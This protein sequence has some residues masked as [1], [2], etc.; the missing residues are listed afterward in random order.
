MLGLGCEGGDAG[1]KELGRHRS[2]RSKAAA[3]AASKFNALVILRVCHRL[4][5]GVIMSGDTDSRNAV[6]QQVCT[7][8][9]LICYGR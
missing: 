6:I 5:V 4:H 3:S 2:Q 1:V 8:R 7:F 9:R